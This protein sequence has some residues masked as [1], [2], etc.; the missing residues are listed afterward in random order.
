[1][2]ANPQKGE[3]SLPVPDGE[4]LTVLLSINA[5]C[6]LEERL[7]KDATQIGAMIVTNQRMTFM[8]AVLWAGLQEHHPKIDEKAAGRIIALVGAPKAAEVM[9]ESF[10]KAF[11]I[12]EEEGAAADE[13]AGPQVTLDEAGT[14]DASTASGA[15]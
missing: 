5:L 3:V 6:L 14:G 10:T 13:E 12:G 15:S 8:R 9:L 2:A 4:T 1:M 7:D 11:G